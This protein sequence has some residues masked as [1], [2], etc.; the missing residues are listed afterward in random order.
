MNGGTKIQPESDEDPVGDR[1]FSECSLDVPVLLLHHFRALS[2][3]I[4][5]IHFLYLVC[6]ALNMK[7]LLLIDREGLLL[8]KHLKIAF[9]SFVF[10]S[11]MIA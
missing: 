6:A 9:D 4:F 1:H 10:H 5:S 11:G 3:F 7:G 2:I 8:I